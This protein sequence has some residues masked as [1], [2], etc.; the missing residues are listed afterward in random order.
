[1]K[2]ISILIRTSYIH[3][4]QRDLD[5]IRFPDKRAMYRQIKHPLLRYRTNPH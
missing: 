1:L 4:F 3:W 2:Y 5:V